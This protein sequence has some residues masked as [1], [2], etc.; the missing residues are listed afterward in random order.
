MVNVSRDIPGPVGLGDSVSLSQDSQC[1]PVSDSRG[2]PGPVAVGDR[3]MV[4]SE[5]VSKIYCT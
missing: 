3:R 5:R 2:I 4:S 1:R